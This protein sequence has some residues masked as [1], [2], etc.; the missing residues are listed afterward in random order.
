MWSNANKQ[1]N[2]QKEVRKKQ[3][4]HS[5]DVASQIQCKI[6]WR[7]SIESVAIAIYTK[8]YECCKLD[9]IIVSNKIHFIG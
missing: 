7:I 8:T 9:L 1:Q 2:E 3:T 4:T 5:Y 6:E